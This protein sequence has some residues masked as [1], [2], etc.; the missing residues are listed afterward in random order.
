VRLVLGCAVMGAG[1]W[2]A[3]HRLDW[4]GAGSLQRAAWMAG[5]LAAAALLYFA[6]LM[7]S[8]LRLREFARRG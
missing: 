1:L 8:G 2:W 4:L 6:T 7:A 3:G 5:V